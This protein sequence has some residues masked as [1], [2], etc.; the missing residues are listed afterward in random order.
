MTVA[1]PARGH[2]PRVAMLEV[3]EERMVELAGAKVARGAD[4]IERA[5]GWEVERILAG[6]RA[7]LAVAGSI[8]ALAITAVFERAVGP[9]QILITVMALGGAL[10]AVLY[11]YARL[12]R[13]CGNYLESLSRFAVVQRTME[14]DRWIRSPSP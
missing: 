4:R 6:V 11:Q 13:L 8:V 14:I 10:A 1:A 9:W 12:R 3:T 2:D 7:A 5:Y